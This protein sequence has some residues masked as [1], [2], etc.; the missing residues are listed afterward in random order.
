MKGWRMFALHVRNAY[1]LTVAM[2]IAYTTA[3]TIKRPAF[4]DR[5][6]PTTTNQQP[7]KK[8]SHQSRLRRWLAGDGR[9]ALAQ[10]FENKT[11]TNS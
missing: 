11:K 2:D 8:N 7:K 4:L 9:H 1:E 3:P 6:K 10:Q 5:Q